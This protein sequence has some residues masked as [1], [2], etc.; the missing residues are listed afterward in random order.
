MKLLFVCLGNICRSPAAEAIMNKFIEQKGLTKKILCDSAGTSQY[1]AGYPADPRMRKHAQKKGYYITSLSRAFEKTD[2]NEFDWI[3]TMDDSNY[4]NVLSLAGGEEHKKKILKMADFCKTK[5]CDFIP[6][7]YYGEDKAFL[8]VIALLE[9]SC[10]ELLQY[11]LKN[12][13]V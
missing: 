10:S 1:H 11:L 7:P 12:Q 13:K 2:F 4:K 6:D 9:D 5:N 3:I 8:D